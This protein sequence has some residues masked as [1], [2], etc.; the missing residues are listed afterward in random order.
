M[1]K[2]QQAM[3]SKANN[4]L[5]E[6]EYQIDC[7]LDNNYKST[8][9]MFKYLKQLK[10]KRKIVEIMRE[11][12][13]DMAA[14]LKSDDEQIVEAYSFMTA[15]QKKKFIKF[16]EEKIVGGIDEYITKSEPEWQKESQARIIQN[17]IKRRSKKRIAEI[18]QKYSR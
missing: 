14:E 12:Y 7:F 11:Q 4:A 1:N 15:P 17:K 18:E 5:G 6:V 2:I 9:S 3:H 13:V 8:F 10:Y 16:I